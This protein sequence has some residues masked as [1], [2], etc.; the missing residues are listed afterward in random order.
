MVLRRSEWDV[1]DCDLLARMAD[2]K[3]DLSLDVYGPEAP[4]SQLGES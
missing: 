4:L 2:L 1:F 3:I